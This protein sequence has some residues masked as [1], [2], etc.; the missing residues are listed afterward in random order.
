M[1]PLM[2][3]KL[4]VVFLSLCDACFR[5]CTSDCDCKHFL[6][7]LLTAQTTR[8]LEPREKEDCACL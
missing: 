1:H 7:P 3:V 5:L 4:V 6:L 2:D 8:R